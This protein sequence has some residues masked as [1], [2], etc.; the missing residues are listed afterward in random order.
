[1][2]KP[3]SF[4]HTI[5]HC[6]S[7]CVFCCRCFG[8]IYLKYYTLNWC[9]YYIYTRPRAFLRPTK[10][11]LDHHRVRSYFADPSAHIN[12]MNSNA[13]SLFFSVQTLRLQCLCL[14]VLLLRWNLYHIHTFPLP[15]I[16]LY[17]YVHAKRPTHA[18]FS[19]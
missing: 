5:T 9:I 2:Y 3:K 18:T 1:V 12:R 6:S 17:L 8:R 7:R 10:H 14:V 11:I 15:R 16:R 13:S 4:L 19:R